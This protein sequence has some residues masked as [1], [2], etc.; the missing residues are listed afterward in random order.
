[1][2][3]EFLKALFDFISSS[4]L[5][6]KKTGE[7]ITVKLINAAKNKIINSN[8]VPNFPYKHAPGVQ[9]GTTFFSPAGLDKRPFDEMN[10]YIRREVMKKA[11]QLTYLLALKTMETASEAAKSYIKYEID[12]QDKVAKGDDP[13]KAALA[14]TS[15]FIF[16]YGPEV[17]YFNE[18]NGI[19]QSLMGSNMTTI[20]LEKF[21]AGYEE[22]LEGKR[23]NIPP[24]YQVDFSPWPFVGDTGPLTEYLKDGYTTA[25]FTGTATYQFNLEGEVLNITVYDTKSEYSFFYH[26][27]WTDRHTREEERIMGETT[28]YYEFSFSLD[29]I[30]RRIKKQDDQE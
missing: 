1:M 18:D 13:L 11:G 30:R 23:T 19:T 24:F 16:G 3:E 4:D 6:N 9:R 7:K 5:L 26:L 28:Q 21:Y 25:Q 20:A 27:W 12:K 14:V 29:E 2:E 17:R 8:P 22:Y 10:E 15:E